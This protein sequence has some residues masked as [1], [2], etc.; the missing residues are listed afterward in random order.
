[1]KKFICKSVFASLP[2]L[3]LL[4]SVNYFGDAAK[5]FDTK[6]ERRMVEIINSGHNV[7]NISN[8]NDRLFLE[9]LVLTKQ[10]VPEIIV[11][12]SSRTK[13]ISSEYFPKKKLLNNSVNGASIQDLIAIYQMY[14]ENNLL[15]EKIILGIDPWTFNENN[16][17][18]RW[19]SLEP[20][21]NRFQTNGS[22]NGFEYSSFKKYIELLSMS[23]FQSSFKNL[24]KTL[25]GQS[26]PIATDEKYNETNTK[27]IDGSLTYE[28]KR[29]KASQEEINSI[30]QKYLVDKV[31]S[32]EGFE[33]ISEKHW[34]EFQTLISELEKNNIQV[35]IFLCPY[36]PIVY[37][38][39]MKNYP[40]VLVA[41]NMIR[42]F[43]TNNKIKLY[44]SFNPMAFGLNET[45][46]YDGMHCKESGIAILLQ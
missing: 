33:K 5:L 37:E 32:I 46:F 24:P 1:M 27:L 6:Y 41:E 4:I 38:E 23:Y 36:A 26:D 19:E 7:T 42:D 17:Q 43:T 10:E 29:R 35:E 2:I 12:G 45:H 13:F 9:E 14:K 11:I 8:Y 21:Y 18:T 16:G 28:K 39:V 22:K 44:G 20:Y 25:A 34:K 40:M 30:I 15:P 31:Y 3:L